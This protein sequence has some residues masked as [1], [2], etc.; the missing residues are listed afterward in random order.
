MNDLTRIPEERVEPPRRSFGE[1]H[2]GERI[3]VGFFDIKV[4]EQECAWVDASAKIQSLP[5]VAATTFL[6]ER[7]ERGII[8][9]LDRTVKFSPGRLS[10]LQTVLTGLWNSETRRSS[11]D[12][13]QVCP[14][15]CPTTPTREEDVE[16]LWRE[17]GA[18]E[19]AWDALR[20]ANSHLHSACCSY[21]AEMQFSSDPLVARVVCAGK[22]NCPS[23]GG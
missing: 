6:G 1:L 18:C 3:V 11:P 2:P 7:T 8:L 15:R 12:L 22:G 19:S 17:L 23:C 21:G 10:S 20:R 16:S 4:D 5:V 9:W 13:H 14:W